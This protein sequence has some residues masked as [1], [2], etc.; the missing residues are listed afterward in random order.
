MNQDPGQAGGMPIFITGSPRSGTSIFILGLK[1]A[2]ELPAFS[3]G[4]LLDVYGKIAVVVDRHYTHY[5]HSAA[6]PRHA[7][8]NV[9]AEEVKQAMARTLLELSNKVHGGTSWIDKSGGTEMLDYIR[10]LARMG[11]P[12][13]T[14][15]CYRRAIENVYSRLQKFPKFD[16]TYH[17]KDWV[18]I[19]RTWRQTRA[20]LPVGTWLEIEQKDIADRPGFVAEGVTQVLKLTPPQKDR[21]IETFSKQRPQVLASDEVGR[22]L[23]I[24]QTGWDTDQ[25]AAFRAEVEEEMR[26]WGFTYDE[27]YRT[28]VAQPAGASGA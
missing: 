2:T 18:N 7:I 27:R 15:F 5:A 28:P 11:Q 19:M 3:E 20:L 25:R 26:I 16:I 23:A 12:F 1:A 4:Q 14:F 8:G 13:V 22:T 10:Q 6:D 17:A 9:S 24:N 21:M